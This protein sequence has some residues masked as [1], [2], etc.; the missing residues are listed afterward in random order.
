[1]GITLAELLVI[2][3]NVALLIVA[4]IWAFVYGLSIPLYLFFIFSRRMYWALAHRIDYD[5][6]EEDKYDI[7]NKKQNREDYE[8]A[9]AAKINAAVEELEKINKKISED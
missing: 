4:P 9:D 1:M 6:D 7:Q 8:D 5:D 2:I 3:G